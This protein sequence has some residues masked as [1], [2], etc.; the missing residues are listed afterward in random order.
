MYHYHMSGLYLKIKNIFGLCPRFSLESVATKN[1]KMIVKSLCICA[2]DRH[3]TVSDLS[4]WM[5]L[6]S[7]T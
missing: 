7:I 6:N 3:F 4:W 2:S 5:N 1:I